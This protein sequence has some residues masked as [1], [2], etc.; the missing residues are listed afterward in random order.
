MVK[1]ISVVLVAVMLLTCLFAAC[2]DANSPEA[3]ILGKW[4]GEES[5]FEVVYVFEEDGV[6]SS[7]TLGMAIPITYEIDGDKITIVADGTS[8]MEDMLGMSIEEIAEAGSLE[9]PDELISTR[10]YT[11]EIKDDVLLLDGVE[12]TKEA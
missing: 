4:V 1:K 6:G 5:G 12:F 7:E 8:V 3:K 10:T 2:A 9:N 11:F